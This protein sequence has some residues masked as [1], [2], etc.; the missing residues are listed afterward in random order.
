M[1]LNGQRRRQQQEE[2]PRALSVVGPT[3]VHPFDKISCAK[4]N[5]QQRRCRAPA[6]S[7]NLCNNNVPIALANAVVEWGLAIIFVPTPH[8]PAR[9]KRKSGRKI[10]KAVV[11]E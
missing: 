5:Q 8:P 11:T 7:Q 3:P 6:G 2:A 1:F 9:T 10:Y 4:L